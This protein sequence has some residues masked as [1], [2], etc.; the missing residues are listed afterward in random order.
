MA[1]VGL[2]FGE[3]LQIADK[4]YRV[5][6][7]GLADLKQIFGKMVFLSVEGQ[8]V[9]YEEDTTQSR[10][11]DG[12]YPTVSTGEVRGIVVGVKSYV[13]HQP[14]FVT[15]T[16]QSLSDIEALKLKNREEV[17]FDN[18]VV[19]YSSV[20]NNQFKLFASAIKRVGTNQAPKPQ[21]Q[22]EHKG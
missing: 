11:Q 12:S 6:N 14:I 1:K 13:Q 7:D 5:L 16:D 4:Q 2:N 8:D 22:E 20:G 3:K 17:D 9:I 19:T 21:K 15:V 18:I 10:R